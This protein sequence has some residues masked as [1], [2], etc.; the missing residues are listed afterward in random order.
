MASDMFGSVSSQFWSGGTE[1]VVLLA[2]F[3]AGFFFFDAGILD[4]RKAKAKAHRQEL[5]SKQ[6][7]SHFSS[8]NCDAVIIGFHELEEVGADDVSAGVGAVVEL[9]QGLDGI[10]KLLTPVLDALRSRHGLALSALQALQGAG[11]LLPLVAEWLAAHNVPLDAAARE[12]LVRGLADQGS[13]AERWLGEGE[14]MNAS[15]YRAL[16]DAAF[17]RKDWR[18]AKIF[19]EFMVKSGLYVPAHLTTA[20]VRLVVKDDLDAALP[21]L[22]TFPIAGEG[23]TTLLAAC[24]ERLAADVSP[25]AHTLLERIVKLATEREVPMLYSSYEALVKAW[26][27]LRDG[28]ARRSFDEMAAR[29][30]VPTDATCLAILDACI[31]A[32][33]VD[34]ARHVLSYL[35]RTRKAPVLAFEKAAAAAMGGQAYAAVLQVGEDLRA[36]G[37]EPTLELA[38]LLR[39]AQA[40]QTRALAAIQATQSRGKGRGKGA[41]SLAAFM[42]SVRDCGRT[43]DAPRALELLQNLRENGGRPDTIACNAVL[44]VCVKAGNLKAARSL[45]DEMKAARLIDA[46]SFNS[47]LNASRNGG[48]R[49]VSMTVTEVD[50]VLDE[51]RES[52]VVPTLVTYNAAINTAVVSRDSEAAWRYVTALQKQGLRADSFT[53]SILLKSV[54]DLKT[55]EEVDRV[56]HLLESRTDVKADDVLC[57]SLLDATVKLKDGKRLGAALQQVRSAGIL[58]TGHAYSTVLRALGQNAAGESGSNRWAEAQKVWREMQSRGVQATEDSYQALVDCAVACGDTEA[59]LSALGE[60]KASKTLRPTAGVY[61]CLIRGLVLSKQ[62]ER[63]QEMYKEMKAEG[64]PIGLVT[65]NTLIDAMSRVGDVDRAADLF[66]DMCAQGISPDLVTYS[67]VIKGY[68]VQGDLEQAIQLFTLMRKRGLR[69]DQILFNSLLSGCATAKKPM[70]ALAEQVLRDMEDA[71]VPVTN[72]TLSILVKL[73]GRCD[74]VEEAVRI[75]ESTSEKNGF[76]V[77]TAVHTCLLQAMLNHGRVADAL[78]VFSSMRSPDAKTY[79]SLIRGCL[80]QHRIAE[81][82]HVADS[83]LRCG[84]AL[85]PSLAM[86]VAS[87]ASRRRV[88]LPATLASLRAAQ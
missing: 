17:L 53:C 8:G 57:S 31:P 3:I 35:R 55:P 39:R 18:Q 69:P 77:N 87:F 14:P 62:M 50:T 42:A 72:Y 41:G 71:R 51:M 29:C 16:V 63:A 15:T 43:R 46:A 85:D 37:A 75:V 36:E 73:Y 61:A 30:C 12:V 5:A 54:K 48:V 60:L 40:T 7:Q 22:S 20:L 74:D 23:L 70:R 66:R 79:S 84:G 38:E 6:L 49:G 44:D 24:E 33:N 19:L 45:L 67:T 2:V 83:A 32:G 58:P 4:R 25:D 11:A 82:V 13:N 28:R 27:R 9:G 68:C 78:Q 64:L 86:D 26:A 52:G 65:Y 88:P 10:V 1:I 59:A 80:K 56:L 81:A 21:L 34:L 47:M 76:E